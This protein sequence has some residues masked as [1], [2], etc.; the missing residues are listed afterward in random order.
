MSNSLNKLDE[1]LYHEK[2]PWLDNNK[3]NE[4]FASLIS[5]VK[6]VELCFNELYEFDFYRPLNSK[7]EYYYKLIIAET[8]RFCNNMVDLINEDDNA[9]RQK[10]WF[11]N[12]V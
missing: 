9:L 4:K 11:D 3:P 2:Q 5:K 6:P 8:N 12:K 7:M 1:I 10:Y